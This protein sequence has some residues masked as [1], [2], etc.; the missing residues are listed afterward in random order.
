M[1]N[2]PT[3]QTVAQVAVWIITGDINFEKLNSI[4]RKKLLFK[5][6]SKLEDKP[7]V[8][9]DDIVTAII[10]L[11]DAGINVSSKQIYFEKIAL[12]KGLISKNFA[13][14]SYSKKLLGLE[15][16]E[17]IEFLIKMSKSKNVESRREAVRWLSQLEDERAIESLSN[18]MRDNDRLVRS[19][20]VKGLL[21]MNASDKF[22][23]LLQDKDSD[24]RW[25]AVRAL[26]IMLDPQTT[27]ALE[28]ALYDNDYLVA[29]EA[30]KTLGKMDN[31]KAVKPLSKYL[32]ESN[33]SDIRKQSIELLQSLKDTS[34]IQ[35]LEKAMKSDNF[36]I[37]MSA[38]EVLSDWKAIHIFKGI[39]K[40][41]KE[42]YMKYRA[43][44][45]VSEFGDTLA[46][47]WLDEVLKDKIPVIRFEAGKALLK[48]GATKPLYRL[49]K[50]N[51]PLM[52]IEALRALGRSGDNFA[53]DS[54][55]LF[56]HDID[57][58]VRCYAYE[59][60]G[61]IGSKMEVPQILESFS[62]ESNYL[63]KQFAR[64][65]LI[66][67][68]YHPQ[69]ITADTT[70]NLLTFGSGI[71]I[72]KFHIVH[73]H[74]ISS[75]YGEL[76][77]GSGVLGYIDLTYED[78]K[79][80]FF[81]TPYDKIKIDLYIINNIFYSNYTDKFE[82]KNPLALNI[83][84]AG[85]SFSKQYNF[86]EQVLWRSNTYV[87]YYSHDT[88][89][90]GRIYVDVEKNLGLREVVEKNQRYLINY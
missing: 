22:I 39:L 72:N 36:N 45:V 30:A 49:L 84:V 67:L 74:F 79:D 21:N 37:A 64:N 29:V 1:A 65:S 80:S 20:A 2:N 41:P 31:P 8:S 9:N 14:Q 52:R 50:D 83:N 63:V 56:I 77:L 88:N 46:I 54:V 17:P 18:S 48:L 85:A 71:S 78:G 55:K 68:G 35:S 40:D 53:V 87:S 27:T 58:R 75:C 47:P 26:G 24:V 34:A 82:V 13:V 51:N 7:A 61:K 76:V 62:K 86:C 11:E 10:L 33:F 59:T 42:S 3:K 38:L 32:E 70:H 19:I 28:S 23:S 57:W 12:I 66:Q 6:L 43:I 16:V 4:Y 44:Q 60:L 90:L 73:H 69:N 81:I 15:K 25:R 89:I 5:D